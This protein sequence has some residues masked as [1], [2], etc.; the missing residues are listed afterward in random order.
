MV[1][2]A[3]VSCAVFLLV[4]PAAAI[5]Q[6]RDWTRSVARTAD[7]AF[8]QGN[9]NAKVKVVEY[10][11]LTC[12]H[13]AHFEQ[14]GIKPLTANYIRTGLVSYEVRHI[15]FNSL[16]FTAS[17]MARCNGPAFFFSVTPTVFAQQTKWM[18]QGI[19]WSKTA[20]GL[21]KLKPEQAL[22]VIAAGAG[23]DVLF[24]S[25]GLPKAKANA[26]LGNLAELQAL[27]SLARDAQENRGI[28][29]TPTFVINGTR[30]EGAGTWANVEAALKAALAAG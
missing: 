14:E 17:I 18:T 3:F 13:C 23:L 25:R 7:G 30:M 1:R 2:R 15:L 28:N 21:E 8:V 22:P 26:C 29:A 4:F 24:A 10:L 19:A 9:P 6:A 20:K 11:S 16:D 12:P 27:A 5:A